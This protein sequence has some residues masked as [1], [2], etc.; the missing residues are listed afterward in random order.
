MIRRVAF[1]IGACLIGNIAALA[2]IGIFDTEGGVGNPKNKGK[3]VY[4]SKTGEYTI[5]GSGQNMYHA[6]DQF[7]FV[8]KKIVGDFTVRARSKGYIK[9]ATEPNAD[10]KAGWMIRKSLATGSVYAGTGLHQKGLVSLLYR[11]KENGETGEVKDSTKIANTTP[12]I[13][14]IQ[15]KGNTYIMGIAIEGATMH[16][17]TLDTIINPNPN[18]FAGRDRP[19]RVG[20]TAYVGLYVCSKNPDALETF[21]FDSVSIVTGNT[22]VAFPNVNPT[23]QSAQLSLQSLI[24][25]PELYSSVSIFNSL[26]QG[27]RS[28]DPARFT[29]QMKLCGS[30]VY[31]I[32]AQTLAGTTNNWRFVQK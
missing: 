30:G 29:S 14:Q 17:D 15:R 1:V 28:V 7:H 27:I 21:L 25:N 12:N 32:R 8:Y 22:A 5:T 10:C 24:H 6:Q 4:D 20:D 16:Y 11:A 31:Y 13:T 2:Q 23:M 3:V 18:D 9:Q 26:G 19:A